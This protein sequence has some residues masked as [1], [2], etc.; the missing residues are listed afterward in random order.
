MKILFLFL[1]IFNDEENEEDEP[2]RQMLR[3]RVEEL[4]TLIAGVS[5]TGFFDATSNFP[6]RDDGFFS[7]C[8]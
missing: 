4:E 6:H 8:M 5:G 1:N 2:S 7:Y 3:E